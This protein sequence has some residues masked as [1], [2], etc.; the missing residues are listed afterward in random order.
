MKY[1]FILVFV[2][3]CSSIFAQNEI[4]I[5]EKSDS[6]F[7]FLSR[8][9]YQPKKLDKDFERE[10]KL[11]F[12]RN[13][14]PHCNFFLAQDSIFI[15]S[16]NLLNEGQ[17]SSD[18]DAFLSQV[19]SRLKK[20]IESLDSMLNAY[21]G[22]S[23][24][25]NDKFEKML[26]LKQNQSS[27]YRKTTSALC[28]RELKGL[29][30]KILLYLSLSYDSLYTNDKT[31][32]QSKI[33]EAKDL[34]VSR[35]LCRLQSKL[36]NDFEK[37]IQDA[38]LMSIANTFD[39]H[40]LY[41][42]Y[43]DKDNFKHQLSREGYS[44]GLYLEEDDKGD[45]VVLNIVPG[46]PAWQCNKINKGDKLISY[47]VKS[48]KE[49]QVKCND[50]RI[51]DELL[52][53]SPEREITLTFEKAGAGKLETITL[54]KEKQIVEENVLHGYVIGK[55]NKVGY[56]SLPGFYT[57]WNES[58]VNGC[59]NDMAKEILKLKKD[60]IKGLIIDLRN[61]GGGSMFEA[62][63]LAGIFVNEGPL[64]YARYN[65]EK[66]LA[67]KDLNRGTVYD[68]P[69]VVIVNGR[70]ASA[71]ELFAAIL[72]DYNRAIVVGSPT[73]GKAT[74]QRVFDLPKVGG[75]V[76][77]TVGKFYRI[78]GKG[79]QAIGIMP[80]INL[81]NDEYKREASFLCALSNDTIKPSPYYMP[82]KS[83]PVRA[84][85]NN[86]KFVSKNDFSKLEEVPLNVDGF[87]QVFKKLKE[88]DVVLDSVQ[89]LNNSSDKLLLKINEM[90]SELNSDILEEI[91]TDKILSDSYKIIT[92]YIN[93]Q[94]KN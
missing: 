7:S 38:F 67:L 82:L 20:R 26:F 62:L 17:F 40:S 23:I 61:N 58:R 30:F 35:E 57:D 29:K 93:T 54:E 15:L 14:D 79:H 6:V 87:M 73:F 49:I 68:D 75:S 64:F 78:C 1:L 45:I 65:K 66:P 46:S 59:A 8:T 13:L 9:H 18:V 91:R 86:V 48:G 39:A 12:L 55:Q 88:G 70:S 56:I 33:T 10:L 19:S 90:K 77:V 84:I 81:D 63:N 92:E 5:A 76:N 52:F 47:K 74:I 28:Q 51:I 32:F 37:E 3:F 21:A 11:V 36:K 41:L 89:V 69:I 85:E 25:L 22:L 53:A 2:L 44:C 94:N 42:S 72:Q 27:Y 60:S 24:P 16:S 31:Q 4:K 50:L 34:I 71:S 43:Q 83:I 80:D